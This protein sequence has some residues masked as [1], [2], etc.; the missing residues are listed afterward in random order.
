MT[1]SSTCHYDINNDK[2]N[3]YDKVM[4]IVTELPGNEESTDLGF[5][6]LD[7]FSECIAMSGKSR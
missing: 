7:D 1:L 5:F 6:S 3:Q 2:L 4:F